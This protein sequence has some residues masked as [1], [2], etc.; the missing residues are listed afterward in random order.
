MLSR[1]GTG[2]EAGCFPKATHDDDPTEVFP[3]D[4]GLYDVGEGGEGEENAEE[5]SSACGGAVVVVGI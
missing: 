4:T 2:D 3:I 5:E 1:K